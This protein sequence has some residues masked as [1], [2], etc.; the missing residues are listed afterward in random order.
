MKITFLPDSIAYETDGDETLL[1]AAADAGVTIASDCGGNGTCG[2][3]RVRVVFGKTNAV[4][5]EEEKILRENELADGWRLACLTIPEENCIVEIPAA[6]DGTAKGNIS[7]PADFVPDRRTD[8]RYGVAFDIGTTTVAGMLCDLREGTVVSAASRAN[9]QGAHGADVISRIECCMKEKLGLDTLQDAV[10]GCL[11]DIA[12]ELEKSSGAK[13]S[14]L[15]CAVAVGNTTM[16][17]ILLG[18]D[19][20][21]LARSPFR[22]V[23]LAHEPVGARSVGLKLALGARLATLPNIAGH[24]G[25]DITAAILSSRIMDSQNPAMLIDIGTNGEMAFVKNGR[26]LVCSTAA[27][28]AFEGAC[29]GCGMRAAPGAIIRT[30]LID[31][32]FIV[33]SEDGAR[34]V[35][36]CGSGLIDIVALLLDHHVINGSGRLLSPEKARE[37]GAPEALAAR[38]R[39]EGRVNAFVLYEDDEH[40]L[41][42]SQKDIRE[43]QLAKAAVAAG[44]K[45]LMKELEITPG[46]L[47][48]VMLAGA[49]GSHIRAKSALR[50]GLLPDVPEQKVVQLGNAA[51]AGACMALLSRGEAARAQELARAAE[52]VELASHPDFQGAFISAMRF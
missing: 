51:G 24:V 41:T 5:P 28:P 26:L 12:E 20:Q 46:D 9:P 14:E 10:V 39:P 38:I 11:N 43:V 1:R 30:E 27:G 50:L 16:T 35:G 6:Q 47:S 25:A 48:R 23:F 49:F 31:G 17:H 45:L 32:R 44:M 52:H 33:T 3:C 40:A 34:P 22:P 8:A 29:I 2:K 42:L 18:V 19:P 36:I 37:K 15:S 4:T 13:R 21:S 7:L